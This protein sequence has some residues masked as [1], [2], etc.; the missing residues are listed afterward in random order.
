MGFRQK[1]CAYLDSVKNIKKANAYACSECLKTGDP[2][3]HLRTCQDCGVTL[4]CDSSPNKH[5]SKHAKEQNHVVVSSAEPQEKW[6]WCYIH[7]TIK[8]YS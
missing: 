3:V 5:A 1:S 2:W 7:K 4:C 6:L 8:E